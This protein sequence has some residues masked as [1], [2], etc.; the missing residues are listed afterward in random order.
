MTI[1][2]QRVDRVKRVMSPT[3]GLASMVGP[4]VSVRALTRAILA[5]LEPEMKLYML[6]MHLHQI[7]TSWQLSSP[8]QFMMRVR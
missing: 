1:G 2:R 8:R 4:L 5:Q 3:L 6:P 7:K